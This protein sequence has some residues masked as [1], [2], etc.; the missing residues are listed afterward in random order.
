[1]RYI[2]HYTKP[3]DIVLD[4]FGGSGMTGVAA[5]MCGCPDS[6]FKQTIENEWK[7]A[8]LN[9][10]EWGARRAILN[11]IGVAATFIEANYNL[12]FDVKD[13]EK[14]AQRI[15]DELKQEI[16]WMYETLHTDGKTKGKINYTVWSEVFACP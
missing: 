3:G 16:G 8:G 13:F 15:L 1:M 5:Q 12:P 6:Q 9:L 10:P 7:S 14:E 11:D 4:G 2:L